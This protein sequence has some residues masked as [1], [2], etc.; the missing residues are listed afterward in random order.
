M[1][2][3]KWRTGGYLGQGSDR[4]VAWL[5]ISMTKG[6]SGGPVLLM[7]ADPAKIVSRIFR[8][9][10]LVS[11]SGFPSMLPIPLPAPQAGPSSDTVLVPILSLRYV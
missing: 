4:D 8:T 7:S 3:S 1:L 9:F 6:N 11:S 10:N 2:S 5:D